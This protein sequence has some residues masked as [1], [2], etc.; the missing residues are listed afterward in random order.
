MEIKQEVPPRKK[1]EGRVY[2][3]RKSMW[4]IRY[5]YIKDAIFSYKKEQTDKTPRQIIDLRQARI[6]KGTRD[7]GEPFYVISKD[8]TTI[9]L[10]PSTLEDY[11]KWALVLAESE[12][13][14]AKRKEMFM[15]PI[16]EQ[17]E[18]RRQAEAEVEKDA[19]RSRILASM[20]AYRKQ[21]NKRFCSHFLD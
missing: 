21:M 1:I 12:Q 19:Q 11:K 4:S 2:I 16:K 3:M 9:K 5:A 14:D 6:T 7:S 15:K 20:I 18:N 17:D 13:S 8:N 10:R